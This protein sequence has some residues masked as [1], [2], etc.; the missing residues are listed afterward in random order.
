MKPNPHIADAS[1]VLDKFS[2]A[3]PF[4]ETRAYNIYHEEALQ[5]LAD[6]LIAGLPEK[7]TGMLENLTPN[8]AGYNKGLY[9]VTKII[10]DYFGIKP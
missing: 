9:E 4:A 2:K 6:G 3:H 5:A 1:I 7:F 10:K 8:E